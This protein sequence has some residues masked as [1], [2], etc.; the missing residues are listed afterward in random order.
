MSNQ[1][2]GKKNDSECAPVARTR[3]DGHDIFLLQIPAQNVTK[4]TLRSGATYG[5]QSNST[6]SELHFTPSCPCALQP[7]L[8]ITPVSVMARVCL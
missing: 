2:N 3:R 5:M 8:K 7:Q 6:L 1:Q 4:K